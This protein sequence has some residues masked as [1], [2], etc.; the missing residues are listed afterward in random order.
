MSPAQLA[1]DRVMI[2]VD[3]AMAEYRNG[4]DDMGMYHMVC[5]CSWE[6]AAKIIADVGIKM[7]SSVD[8]IVMNLRS[9]HRDFGGSH[10][11]F[12]TWN[13]RLSYAEDIVRTAFKDCRGDV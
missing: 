11:N 6:R 13:R 10:F 5:L 8:D 7:G 9:W 1:Y 12:A 2:E 4:A 3:K